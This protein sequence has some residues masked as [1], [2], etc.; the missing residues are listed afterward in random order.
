MMVVRQE[1]AADKA[2]REPYQEGDEPDHFMI[3]ARVQF[4]KQVT[5]SNVNEG[6]RRDGQQNS[7]RVVQA[8]VRD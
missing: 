5:S 1:V 8:F 6:A 4:R 3:V 7:R 2:E